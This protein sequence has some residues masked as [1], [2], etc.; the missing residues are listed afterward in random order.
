MEGDTEIP[1]KYCKAAPTYSV[2]RIVLC[3]DVDVKP[4]TVQVIGARLEDGYD[5][6]AGSPGMLKESKG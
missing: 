2:C 6:N 3:A 4:G 5:Q 1:I